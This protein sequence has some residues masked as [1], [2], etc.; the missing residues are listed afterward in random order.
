M[1]IEELVALHLA[2]PSRD[3]SLEQLLELLDGERD[4]RALALHQTRPHAMRFFAWA[5]ASDSGL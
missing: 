2:N 5:I 1:H 4:D 3:G